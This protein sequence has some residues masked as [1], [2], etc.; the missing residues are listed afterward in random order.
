[1]KKYVDISS[2]SLQHGHFSVTVGRLL[3]LD[4]TFFL[5]DGVGH[6][7]HKFKCAAKSVFRGFLD[8]VEDV[9]KAVPFHFIEGVDNP[10]FTTPA[11]G[12]RK[13]GGP[14]FEKTGIDVVGD[15]DGIDCE[16]CCGGGWD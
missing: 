10:S 16:S 2:S 15:G 12:Y 7:N 11:V 14:S 1:M 13:F 4:V 8:V 3:D 6:V 9:N 5:S